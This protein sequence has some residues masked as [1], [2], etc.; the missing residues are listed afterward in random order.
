MPDSVDRRVASI[1][2]AGAARAYD[3]PPPEP[4]TNWCEC[5]HADDEHYGRWGEL[6]CSADGCGCRKFEAAA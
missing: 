5:G 2:Y 6:H 4:E 3:Y 1:L